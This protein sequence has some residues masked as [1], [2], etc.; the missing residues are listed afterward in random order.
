MELSPCKDCDKR[1]IGCHSKCVA[2]TTFRKDLD[3]YNKTRMFEKTFNASRRNTI[4]RRH[5]K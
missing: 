2:Y 4:K 5:Y 3:L 1:E